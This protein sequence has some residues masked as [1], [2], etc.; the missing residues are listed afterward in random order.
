MLRQFFEKQMNPEVFLLFV[1][2]GLIESKVR[3]DAW[4][5]LFYTQRSRKLLMGI[6]W[7][8]YVRIIRKYHKHLTNFTASRVF[9]PSFYDCK[10][11]VILERHLIFSFL[12]IIRSYKQFL[13]SS[14]CDALTHYQSLHDSISGMKQWLP[15]ARAVSI[16]RRTLPS[17]VPSS[18][19]LRQPGSSRQKKD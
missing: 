19:L 10:T 5:L 11:A 8:Q 6:N 16:S 15:K 4:Q 12:K 18:F 13:W 3:W 17:P 2:N 1:R 9:K 7:L 14:S